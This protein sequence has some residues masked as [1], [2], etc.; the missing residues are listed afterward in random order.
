[1][2]F[3]LS[4]PQFGRIL[5][6]I[7]LS[8]LFVAGTAFARGQMTVKPVIELGWQRDS[9]FH[10]T[11]TDTQ[12]VDTYYVKP[13]IKFGFKAPKS[14]VSLDYYL[15]SLNYDDQ[16]TVAAGN[17]EADDLDYI[18]HQLMFG[19]KNQPS[20]R[21]QIGLDD[22]FKKTRDP[23]STETATNDIE[24][25]KYTM[26]KF[27]PWINYRFGEKFGLGLKYTNS[28]TNYSDDDA[29]EGED[30][31]EN[32]GTFTFFYY[33][34]PK[35]SFDLD[36]QVWNRDYDKDT[37][38]YTS[39]QVMLNVK[40]QINY[41]TFGAG[42]GY[43]DRDFDKTVTGGDIQKFVWKLS[44]QGQNAQDNAPIPRSSM[45]LSLGSNLNDSG[46]G[47]T[48]YES[49]RLDAKFTY[50]FMEKLNGT[51]KAWVQNSDYETSAREDDKWFL[52]GALDYLINDWVAV[53]IEGGMEQRNSNFADKD[54][55]NEYIQFNISANYDFG[56]K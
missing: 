36:Y 17:L 29:G 2:N 44:L 14:S 26:N 39:N 54:Y 23:S 4:T 50:L 49:I 40:H 56:S 12:T 19:A 47:D 45:Y 55:E 27:T 22:F 34:T 52:S 13:G 28:I 37:S 7:F 41:L 46:A 18:E 33:F 6:V 11:D 30:T 3:K 20:D 51:L 53:G 48:Y 42:A 31:D 5:A 8:S 1:M 43:H 35:T 25:Y 16:D 38:E 21:L 10:K 9:N 15:N 24:T 32:R